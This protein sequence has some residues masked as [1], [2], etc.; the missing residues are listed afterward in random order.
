MPREENVENTEANEKK[1]EKNRLRRL[2]ELDKTGDKA[3]LLARETQEMSGGVDRVVP[4]DVHGLKGQE[5]EQERYSSKL[6]KPAHTDKP[7]LYAS[8]I[9]AI[10]TGGLAVF[11]LISLYEIS[12]MGIYVFPVSPMAFV[13]LFIVF[14]VLSALFIYN[15]VSRSRE[16]RAHKYLQ[17][18]KQS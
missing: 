14:A 8:V 15:A 2:T 5:E 13:L 9:A 16:I 10:I 18:R 3:P 11:S 1:T 17:K 6:G 12:A 4:P 7:A